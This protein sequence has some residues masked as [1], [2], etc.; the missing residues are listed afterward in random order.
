M[1][2]VSVGS[3]P[4]QCHLLGC[5]DTRSCADSFLTNALSGPGSDAEFWLAQLRREEW[6]L[7]SVC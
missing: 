5:S 7:S 4:C 3:Q 2:L 1:L 6:G